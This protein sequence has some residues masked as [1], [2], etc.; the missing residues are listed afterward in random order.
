MHPFDQLPRE[1]SLYQIEGFHIQ[2]LT[3][4]YE[5]VLNKWVIQA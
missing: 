2:D 5:V 1:P 4:V 3:F